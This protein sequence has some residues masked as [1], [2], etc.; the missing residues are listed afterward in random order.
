MIKRVLH[1]EPTIPFRVGLAKTYAWIEQQYRD[2]QGP[3]AKR[4]GTPSEPRNRREVRQPPHPGRF[5][6]ARQPSAG[7]PASSAIFPTAWPCRRLDRPA[8][9]LPAESPPAGLDGRGRPAADVPLHGPRRHGHRHAQGRP[10][11]LAG[12][13]AGRAAPASWSSELYAEE[14][15]GKAEPSGSQDMIG[16]IYPGVSRLDFDAAHERRHLSPC[17]SS[18][19]TIPRSPAGWSASSM[20]PVAPRPEGYNPLGSK[21]LDPAVDPPAGPVGQGLLRRDRRPRRR[22]AGRVDE[23]VHEVLG[24]APARIPSGIPRSPSI[25][26]RCC[27]ITSRS[28]RARCIPAAAAAT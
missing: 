17:T 25:C 27:A 4:S 2:P 6:C 8:V 21:H 14:N 13:V 12:P 24:G 5:P 20:L 10:A 23:R 19:T 7:S 16:L 26:S 11:A 3:D 22:A 28:I 9:R 1:W 18:R 15:R